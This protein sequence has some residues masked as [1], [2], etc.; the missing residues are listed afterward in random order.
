MLLS[1]KGMNNVVNSN[2][3]R[4][5]KS[6][7]EMYLR[8]SEFTYMSDTNLLKTYEYTNFKKHKILDSFIEMN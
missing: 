7:P 2:L 5:I 6:T 4:V 1:K 3:M 8:H